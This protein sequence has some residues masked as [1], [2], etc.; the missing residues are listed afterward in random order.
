MK[1]TTIIL[2]ILS[3]LMVAGTV[4]YKK[5]GKALP[6]IITF[7]KGK[8]VVIGDRIWMTE[9]MNVPVEGSWCYNNDEANCKIY[10]RLYTWEAAQKVCPAGW[11]LPT[12]SE[13]EKLAKF[14]KD[15]KKLRSKNYNEWGKSV[16]GTD[17]YGFNAHPSGMGYELVKFK[18]GPVPPP[19]EQS[20]PNKFSFSFDSRIAPSAYFWTADMPTPESK[21]SYYFDVVEG[22]YISMGAYS[23][24]FSEGDNIIR[25]SVIAKKIRGNCRKEVT[26]K[27]QNF[28]FRYV[29]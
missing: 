19:K 3:A 14:V 9:N 15:S 10:G 2:L 6:T 20:N 22:F 29:V 11:H 1:K 21:E 26:L 5:I 24:A 4:V 27:K 23:N 8:T 12:G 28:G 25:E 16:E 7:A 13:F 17:D 18:D